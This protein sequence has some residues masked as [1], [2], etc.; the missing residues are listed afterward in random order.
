MDTDDTMLPSNLE[1][2]KREL[3][4][5]EW[6]TLYKNVL[7]KNAI[8]LTIDMNRD[9]KLKAENPETKVKYTEGHMQFEMPVKMRL[10]KLRIRLE[11]T[12]STL[13]SISELLERHDQVRAEFWSKEALLTPEDV[14]A[15][16]AAE[17]EENKKP[18]EGLK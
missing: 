7:T 10:E 1:L 6:L 8:A 2:T 5:K 11:N 4:D 9:A 17:D 18:D 3:T 13:T 15:E 14:K 16:I 12:L